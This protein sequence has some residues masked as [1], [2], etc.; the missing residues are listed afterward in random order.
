MEPEHSAADVRPDADV[1]RLSELLKRLGDLPERLARA[2]E[3]SPSAD[4]S[5]PGTRA[6]GHGGVSQASAAAPVLAGLSGMPERLQAALASLNDLMPGFRAGPSSVAPG[7]A[8][9]SLP[10]PGAF[11]S[12][13][14]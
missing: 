4:F 2:L 12:A 5:A 10:S 13:P 14:G 6:S 9:L 8:A 3:Q 1:Q 11:S 7:P